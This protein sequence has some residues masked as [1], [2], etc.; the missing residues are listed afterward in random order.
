LSEGELELEPG[1]TLESDSIRVRFT[2]RPDGSVFGD[3]L[4]I[5]GRWASS[6]LAIDRWTGAIHVDAR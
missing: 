5:R 1:V 2:F 3:T 6:R 4:T